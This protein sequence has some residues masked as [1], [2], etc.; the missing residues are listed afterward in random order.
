MTEQAARLYDI[1]YSRYA[2]SHEPRWRGVLAL[3]KSSG[4]R[5]LG[6]R[7]TTGAKVWPFLLIGVAH[8]PVVAAVGIPLLF[9]EA[10]PPLELVTYTGVL[11]TILPVIIAFAATTLPSLLTRE[12][13]D[14]VL[15]LYFSTALSP[16]EYLAG[17]VLA[18]VLLMSLVSLS[19]LLI[20]LA[21]AILTAD[22]PLDA[23]QDDGGDVLK[24]LAAALTVAVYFAALGLLAGS[25]TSKR[26]F[27]VGGL[28]AVLLVTPVIAGV[29]SAL[30]DRPNVA[31]ADLAVVSMR[32]ADTLLPGNEFE[33][34]GQRPDDTL[35]WGVVGG[36]V[37]LSAA[38]LAL[39][40]RNPD[41]S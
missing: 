23:L 24:V 32:A 21:G 22:A 41:A 7:R 12:R 33:D 25:L 6:L 36:A 13:R 4:M 30:A 40:Y 20:L 39:R 18:A 5:A 34:A 1:R 38:V 31:A 16:L 9:D 11:L 10:P 37:A 29:V 35:V 19:P 15:S 27:A 14:R 8:L 2:G 3:A 17:K 28:L 26:V